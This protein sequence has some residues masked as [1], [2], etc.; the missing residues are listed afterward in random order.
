[1]TGKE[2][3]DFR[4]KFIA[5]AFTAFLA[6]YGFMVFTA[7]NSSELLD[8]D[9]GLSDYFYLGAAFF[10]FA[11]VVI[12][13]FCYGTTDNA[14]KKNIAAIL[15]TLNLA[16]CLC[17]LALRFRLSTG[18]PDPNLGTPVELARYLEWAYGPTALIVIFSKIT[19]SKQNIF[20]PTISWLIMVFLGW[21][22]MQY[23]E[24]W[25]RN[26]IVPAH[27]AFIYALVKIWV[28]FDDALES[29]NPPMSKE[30]LRLLQVH[31]MIAWSIFTVVF[32]GQIGY[33][34]SAEA[35]ECWY[36]LSST[37]T[38]FPFTMIVINSSLNFQGLKSKTA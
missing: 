23:P 15:I 18:L 29:E 22:C 16:E 3:W 37:L 27:M 14:D 11:G 19:Q 35:T 2:G 38:K 20:V 30:I 34:V 1:M 28:M 4:D 25:N 32:I 10:M 8:F 21:A 9:R 5:G 12:S 17:F 24:S 13:A 26:L 6:A 7:W 31:C 36:A 33:V